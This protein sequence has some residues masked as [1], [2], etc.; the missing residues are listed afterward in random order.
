MLR[1]PNFMRKGMGRGCLGFFCHHAYAH[2]TEAGRELIPGAFKGVDLAVFS[3]FSGLGLEVDIHPI[4]HKWASWPYGDEIKNKWGGL[5]AKE[6]LRGSVSDGNNIGDFIDAYLNEVDRK[7]QDMMV[8]RDES[9]SNFDE[10]EE[11]Q[12]EFLSEYFL[13]SEGARDMLIAKNLGEEMTIVG[14]EMHGPK[15]NGNQD[16]D[17]D[18]KASRNTLLMIM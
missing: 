8:D 15:F 6:L 5:P 1:E 9:D 14:S 18:N 2:S 11:G 4:L 16:E 13:F 7:Q 10:D 12:K 3:A 17:L